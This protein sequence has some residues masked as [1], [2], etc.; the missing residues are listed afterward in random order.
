MDR[1]GT[2][3]AGGFCKGRR[4]LL[5]FRFADVPCPRRKARRERASAAER[6][7][8]RAGSW[9]RWLRGCAESNGRTELRLTGRRTETAGGCLASVQPPYYKVL[10]GC[11][12]SGFHLRPRANCHRNTRHSLLLSERHD[13]RGAAFRQTAGV[14]EAENGSEPLRQ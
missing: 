5:R 4:H 3:A 13:V 7:N 8:C 11:G 9:L 2:L 10:V 1:W 12:Q 6:Q 14:C